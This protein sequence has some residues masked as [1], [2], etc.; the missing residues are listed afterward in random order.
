MRKKSFLYG[1]VLVLIVTIFTISSINVLAE[2]S[3]QEIKQEINEL[4]NKKEELKNEKEEI[5]TEQ[6]EAERKIKEKEEKQNQIHNEITVIDQE[7][8]TTMN[9]IEETENE[10]TETKN[11]IKELESNIEELQ[12]R[13]K[14]RNEILKN[15][16]RNLQKSGGNI[17]Y[18]E[19]ILGSKDFGDFLSRT[20]AVN[21]IMGQDKKII[22]EQKKEKKQLEELKVE[23]MEKKE[24]LEEQKQTLVT[25]K[26]KLENQK[27]QKESLMAQ[28]EIEKKELEE[29]KVSLEEEQQ[30]LAG[31][32]KA[33]EKLLKLKNE[34]YEKAKEAEKQIQNVS[35]N[36]PPASFGN[37]TFIRPTSGDISDWFGTRGGDH[38]GIDIA[39]SG[40]VPV[41]A[42]ASGVV[43]RSYSSAS[44]GEVIFITHY[45][46]GQEYTTVYAHLRSG[47][48]AVSEGDVVN[49]GQHIG[50]MGYTGNVI[51]PGERGQHLH[52]ELHRGKWN[53]YKTNAVDPLRYISF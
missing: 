6:Q 31:Q 4:K 26:Q 8:N 27:Q 9:E 35:Q 34:E 33:L 19:V 46:D 13:I 53:L 30:I 37:G 24:S 16:L 23:V 32:E 11:Q 5:L 52:F 12:K 15:R 28:I 50:Y 36:Q 40:L 3:S 18:L 21:K 43:S 7:L 38:Y 45:I 25:L 51:P 17:N 41:Y 10:I 39:R 48:R 2:K 29:Y 22:D 20:S 47:S 42:A 14:E 44:Y 1:S 49:Q